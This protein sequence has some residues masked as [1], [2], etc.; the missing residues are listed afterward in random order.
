VKT[1]DEVQ[2]SSDFQDLTTDQKETARKQYFEEVVAPKVPADK[3]EA[4]RKHFDEDTA[5][6]AK[7]QPPIRTDYGSPAGTGLQAFGA[8]AGKAFVD[9]GR[10]V[11]SMLPSSMGGMTGQ[12]VEASRS[13]DA[14]LMATGAGKLGNIAGNVAAAVPA[15]FVPGANTVLGAGVIG[16]VYGLLQPAKDWQERA[17]A[18]VES[19]L[20]SGGITGLVRAVPAIYRAFVDPFTEA[21]QQRVAMAALQR[22]AKDPTKIAN[23]GAAELIPGSK[24]TLA[25]TTMDPGIAQ[26]QRAAASKSPEVA[27]ELANIDP[28]TGQSR[29]F[30][31]RKDA[32]LKIAGDS[33]DREYFETARAATA[34]RLYGE[35]FKT[36]IDPKKAAKLAPDITELLQRPSVQTA[37]QQAIKLAK[38]GGKDLTDADVGGGSMEGLHYVKTALDDQISAAKRAGDN[39][40]AR[41]LIGTQDKLVGTMQHLSP[42]YA[43]AMAEY[44]A[45][46]K[47]IN[48]MAIGRYL[49]DKLFPAMSDLGAGNAT[50]GM[51]A[52]ALKE[53]DEMAK[54]ATGFKGAKLTDIL[55]PKD[56]DTIVNVG[57]DVAREAQAATM[58]KVPGS[59][60]AQYLTGQNLMRQIM[61][62]LGLPESWAESTM[63]DVMANRWVSLAGKPIET[64][65]QNQ[66][67]SLLSDP[68]KARALAVAQGKP[69]YLP[70]S[71]LGHALPPAAIGAGVSAVGQ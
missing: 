40:L 22:F 50:P 41:L 57:K 46:S 48:R 68:A 44:E 47:P 26:L 33:A 39:N 66:L 36:P 31:A 20:L 24:A 28:V 5:P 67:G 2:N 35:A 69:Q 61:G 18:A 34:Q 29:R 49:Y 70:M 43:K 13:Q 11:R 9:I 37:R 58:A 32:L 1:W 25:E 63:A 65:I 8:G 71:A 59:P 42:K 30:L 52:K 12:Q 64:K 7:R 14:P 62:P 10:G 19:A 21:G 45:A 4:V 3:I 55:A 38:E 17:T 53:G 56:I 23:Q 16:A 6:K 15:A 54:K 60:T 51:Y 27:S